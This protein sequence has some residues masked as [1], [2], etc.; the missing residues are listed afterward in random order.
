M[1][2][3]WN[4]PVIYIVENNKY[5]MGTDISRTCSLKNLS[6]KGCSYN[7]PFMQVDGMDVKKVFSSCKAAVEAAREQKTPSRIII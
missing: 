6:E 7:I 2:A 1:A 3:I 5:G 4:L